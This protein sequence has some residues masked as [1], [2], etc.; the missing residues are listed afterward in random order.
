MKLLGDLDLIRW[1]VALSMTIATTARASDGPL[2]GA[3]FRT[4]IGKQGRCFEEATG[5]NPNVGETL[6]SKYGIETEKPRIAG[7]SGLSGSQK[8]IM[9]RIAQKCERL[10]GGPFPTLRGLRVEYAPRFD[11][12]AQQVNGPLEIG[13]TMSTNMINYAHELGHWVGNSKSLVPPRNERWY[14]SYNREVPRCLFTHYCTANHGHGVRNE[15]FAEAF[16]AYLGHPELLKKG[17]PA[18]FNFFRNKM[19]TKEDTKCAN[20]KPIQATTPDNDPIQNVIR[21]P[22]AKQKPEDCPEEQTTPV[23]QVRSLNDTIQTAAHVN[24]AD[25]PDTDWSVGLGQGLKTGVGAA[26]LLMQF[27]MMK[28]QQEQ[29]AAALAAQQAAQQQML[30][31]MS[32]TTVAP[33]LY[34]STPIMQTTPYQ[35][36]PVNPVGAPA[37]APATAPQEAKAKATVVPGP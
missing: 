8:M 6:R 15:E 21:N 23:N 5:D 33:L 31:N 11:D 30:N 22:N 2:A 1:L 16:A 19:F 27:Y 34:N 4:E 7:N 24:N 17:C 20:G 10:Y 35:A 29:Q 26:P 14:D 37:T 3:T 18:A 9:L 25:S 32:N 28:Q 12:Y 36:I 13:R